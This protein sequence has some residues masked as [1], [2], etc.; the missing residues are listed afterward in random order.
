[1]NLFNEAISDLD[2][3]DMPFSGR[4]FS[5]SNM[6]DVEIEQ[7]IKNLPNSHAPGPPDGFNGLFVK[8]CWN[9]IKEDTFRLFK[10]FCEHN[11]DLSVRIICSFTVIS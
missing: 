7:V 4:N 2:L 8:K 5:W 10:D 6:Q 9:I 11:I 3:V 1:M